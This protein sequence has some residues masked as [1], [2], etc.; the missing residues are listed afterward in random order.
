MVTRLFIVLGLVSVISFCVV[1]VLGSFITFVW[2]WKVNFLGS[3]GG[4]LD[5][6]YLA[7]F[8]KLP[9]LSLPLTPSYTTIVFSHTSLPPPAPS[10]LSHT[11]NF[12]LSP[13]PP[14]TF[15]APHPWPGPVMPEGGSS[16]GGAKDLCGVAGNNTTAAAAA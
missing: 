2:G 13:L 4:L 10:S 14:N 5:C 6:L 15:P 8:P 3:S 11:G 7:V 9:T 12:F 16:E 1:V